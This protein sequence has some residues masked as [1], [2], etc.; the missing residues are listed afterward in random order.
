[1][2][3]AAGCLCIFSENYLIW[4][5]TRLCALERRELNKFIRYR[6][7]V[8]TFGLYWQGSSR[9]LDIEHSSHKLPTISYS[10]FTRKSFHI[11]SMPSFRLLL[12]RRTAAAVPIRKVGQMFR[13]FQNSL[14]PPPQRTRQLPRTIS[15]VSHHI[16]FSFSIK[17]SKN[18]E[19]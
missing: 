12:L 19:C 9:S 16:P 7:S 2:V 1:M 13:I 14:K 6:I 11:D 17:L 4:F 10:N 15:T 8:K 5:E 3:S 18:A